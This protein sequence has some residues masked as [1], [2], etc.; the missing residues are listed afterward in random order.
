MQNL[1][2]GT[3]N[4]KN[5]ST[6]ITESNDLQ[7][8]DINSSCY[9]NEKFIGTTVA[10]KASVKLLD[11]GTYSLED[12]DVS[13]KTGV[14]VDGTIEY[15]ALGSYII[16]KPE[17][18][19]ISATTKFS[20]YDYMLKFDI[21][22]VD[23][24]TYPVR[25]DNYLENLCEQ[26]GIT[27]GSKN[28]PNN[29]YMVKG[30]PFTNGET[31]RTVLSNI[32]QLT[33]GFAEVDKDDDKLY[34]RNFDIDGD[35]VETI[36]GNNYDEFK[37]N[38]VF[39]PVNSVRIQMNSGVDGE[40][41]IKEE[42]GLTE[43]TR[44]QIT[45]SD[46]YF[47]TSEAERNLV[48]NNIYNTL[49]G[50]TYL[51]V[52]IN[53]YGYPWLK[54][55]QKIKVKDKND[56]EYI[57]YLMEHNINY[58]GG[59]SGTIASY[60]LSKTQ[61]AY[62]EIKTMKQWKRQT[63]L[64]VDKI[65]GNITSI[66]EEVDEQN[67]KIN[68]VTQTVNELRSQISE[69][70]NVTQSADGYGSVSIANI[71]ESEPVRVKVRPV[72]EDIAYLYASNNLYAANDLYLKNRKIRFATEN[73][74]IDWEIPANL[75]YYDSE[76]YDELI[77]DYE[78]QTCVV[79]KK[80]GYN[81]DGTKYLL[82]IPTT[83]SYPYPNIPLEEGDYTI[84]V[85]GYPNAYLFVRLMVKNLYTTQFATKAEVK[86]TV[87]QTS[88]Q[89]KSEVDAKF[90]NYSTTVQMNSAIDLKVG[91]INIELDKKVNNEDFTKASIIL[92]L[93]DT[94]SQAKINADVI[95]LN[96]NKILNLL[97]G[98]E[99]NLTSNNIVIKSTNFSVDKNGNISCIGGKIG[100]F[101]LGV[102]E[103]S[104]NITLSYRYTDTDMDRISQILM[105]NIIPTASDYEKYDL[106]QDSEI[107]ILDMANINRLILGTYSYDG[108]FKLNT[109]NAKKALQILDS[110][111]KIQVSIGIY[112]SYFNT[113]STNNLST[114]SCNVKGEISV[115]NDKIYIG[116]I[117][118]SSHIKLCNQSD[119]STIELWGY[120]GNISCTSLTQ[121]SLKSKKKN[122]K[123]TK[124]N[125]LELIKN[126]DICEY[127]LKG[128]KPKS[129]KH[130]GLVIGE[131]YKCPKEVISEDGQ[132][133][134]A[135]SQR[136]I[137]WKAIQELL[138]RVERLEA[139]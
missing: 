120:N 133:I 116:E 76:N 12:K 106:S 115:C 89:I 86:S 26:V 31:C 124:I 123:K 60:A 113:L 108:Y 11:N 58:N 66:I 64:S 103:F 70:A 114:S 67:S 125:A 83:N 65:N 37:P 54:L 4:I 15:E 3:V 99:I 61:S 10:K 84:T 90:T 62:K 104:T 63:E 97:A 100:G 51:P 1:K 2:Y 107:D 68:E 33:A 98:N 43:T 42:E 73:Y 57:T 105:G 8:F 52:T 5:T 129:K 82:A 9:V 56:N 49:H 92:K 111:N 72:T 88:Q 112:G 93:N 79:N 137:S 122:I 102:N 101:S 50:L 16:P 22:Y 91:E 96:A 77:L 81:A 128:D 87:S 75:L 78:S 71:N 35:P 25:L 131:G 130:I 30:N 94:S 17:N 59:Y 121:T 110:R 74:S 117:N 19:E 55:G 136:S 138:E 14:E 23:N 18:A 134:E 135:Y 126:A 13:I 36:D 40:E 80:V 29:S 38:N 45:I 21:P 32:T 139:K 34:I 44:C 132:G 20:G 53:Y 41:T 95:D 27:L 7:E 39:G 109:L 24:N 46:N 48:I 85:L 69:V 28:F 118:D 119:F 47:L 6:N 127:N